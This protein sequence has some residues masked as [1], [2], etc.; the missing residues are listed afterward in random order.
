MRQLRLMNE[1]IYNNV[2]DAL[3]SEFGKD[4]VLSREFNYN[5]TQ[6]DLKK[7]FNILNLYLFEN[8]I[9]FLQ[10]VLWPMNKLVD[11]LNYHAKMSGPENKEIKSVR[12]LGVHSSICNEVYNENS[13]V[14]DVKL[15]DHYLIIN[16]SEISNS[17]FIFVVSVICHEM[18]HAYDH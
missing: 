12:C 6:S 3:I 15:R 9:K 4:I 11:K 10:V 13:E 5:L 2:I 14:V 8:K 17:I 18:I 1:S 7:I 16:S